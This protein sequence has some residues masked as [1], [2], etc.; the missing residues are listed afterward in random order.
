MSFT[1]LR[2]LPLHAGNPGPMTGSGNW[3]CLVTGPSPVLI[4]AGVSAEVT[5]TRS[6]ATR[7]PAPP[8]WR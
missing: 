6:G 7:P 5:S 4:D 1:P 3:T 2:V 8:W